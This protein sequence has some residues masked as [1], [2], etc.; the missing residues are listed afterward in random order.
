MGVEYSMWITAGDD[1]VRGNDER[2]LADHVALN[3]EI[4]RL[5]DKFSNGLFYPGEPSGP[6]EEWINCRCAEAPYN[7]PYGYMAPPQEQF[8][9]S[10]LI[11][12]K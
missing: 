4:T 12:I 7:I 11:K 10:D 3:G 8:R 9:E 1:K 2:D 5:G 6:I